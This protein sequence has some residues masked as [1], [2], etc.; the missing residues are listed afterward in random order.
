MVVY[1]IIKFFGFK[2]FG[3]S[4]PPSQHRAHFVHIRVHRLSL[5]Y[6]NGNQKTFEPLFLRLSG[7]LK[8]LNLYFYDIAEIENL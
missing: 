2:I 1:D 5:K 4:A 3:F 7:N 8:L 6:Q